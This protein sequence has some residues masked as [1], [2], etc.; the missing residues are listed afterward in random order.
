MVRAF[1]FLMGVLNGEVCSFFSPS[2]FPQRLFDM[3]SKELQISG[4]KIYDDDEGASSVFGTRQYWD[5]VYTGM[6]DFPKEEYSWYYGYS[7]IKPFL[8]DAVSKDSTILCP[9][10]GN[11]PILLDLYGSGFHNVVAFDYSRYAIDRQKDLLAYQPH[12]KFELYEMDARQLD[13]SWTNKFDA[14]LE[15]GALDAIFLSGGGNLEAAVQELDRVLKPGGVL[16][17]VSGVVPDELRK[18]LFQCYEWVR[19]GTSDLQAG[20]FVFQKPECSA[21]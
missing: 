1:I 19:D 7:V 11:D 3:V 6:G 21:E 16:I 10:I 5:E 2:P 13:K 20:C 8:V 15:K 9:G 17:S 4:T 14:I 18:S 12:A